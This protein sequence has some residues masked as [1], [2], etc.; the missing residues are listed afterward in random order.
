[1]YCRLQEITCILVG[2]VNDRQVIL[3]KEITSS[4]TIVYNFLRKSRYFARKISGR[5]VNDRPYERNVTFVNVGA[6]LWGVRGLDVFCG[7]LGM[8]GP[9][10]FRDGFTKKSPRGSGEEL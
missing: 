1:M 10:E 5:A 8:E 6:P 9:T 3:Q 2:A 7:H 4:Q